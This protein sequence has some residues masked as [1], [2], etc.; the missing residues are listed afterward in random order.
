MKKYLCKNKNKKL[1]KSLHLINHPLCIHGLSANNPQDWTPGTQ[2]STI[3]EALTMYMNLRTDRGG[4]GFIH[5]LDQEV[6]KK[7]RDAS[8]RFKCACGADHSTLFK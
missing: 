3:V 7:C 5:Q 6:I 2:I 4:S 8:V 1:T